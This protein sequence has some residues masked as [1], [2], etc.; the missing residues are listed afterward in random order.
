MKDVYIIWFLIMFCWTIFFLIFRRRKRSC[1]PKFN[2]VKLVYFDKEDFEEL[3]KI[4]MELS[5][6]WENKLKT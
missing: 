2:V 1:R 5:L 4:G 6:E 3:Q